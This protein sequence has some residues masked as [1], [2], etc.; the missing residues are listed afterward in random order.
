MLSLS[1][2]V[3]FLFPVIF[4]FSKNRLFQKRGANI[5]IFKFQCFKLTF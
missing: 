2:C 4:Q 1:V 3:F 5:G